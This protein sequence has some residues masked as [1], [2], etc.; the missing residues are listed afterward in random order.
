MDGMN[1]PAD[2]DAEWKARCDLAALYRLLAHYKMTDL[3][4]THV[5]A[6]VPG[7]AHHF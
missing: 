6:R 4:Y 1:A 5:S 7:P 3:I 2:V